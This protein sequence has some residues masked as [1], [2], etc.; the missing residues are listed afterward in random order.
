MRIASLLLL[1]ASG[2]ASSDMGACSRL[3]EKFEAMRSARR[4]TP[5]QA[6]PGDPQVIR[7]RVA[8]L[9]AAAK[10]ALLN[11]DFEGYQRDM[12]EA[13]RLSVMAEVL[14]A[15]EESAFEMT[16]AALCGM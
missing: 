8:Y 3:K 1:L 14:P 4:S 13:I 5:L 2:C 10:Q 12:N 9:E 15:A 11:N 6:N 16:R 7:Q